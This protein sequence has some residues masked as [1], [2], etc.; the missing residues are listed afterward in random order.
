MPSLTVITDSQTD[1]PRELAEELGILIAPVRVSI[2]RKDCRDKIDISNEEIYIEGWDVAAGRVNVVLCD[3]FLGNILVK[4]SAGLG[5]V[6]AHWSAQQ[7]RG[8][9][10]KPKLEKLMDRFRAL[11]E[12]DERAGGGPLLGIE[13]V[14]VIGHGRSRASS[15]GGAIDQARRAAEGGLVEGLRAELTRVAATISSDVSLSK[16]AIHAFGLS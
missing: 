4:Y 13:G 9:L 12:M 7:L 15:V 11:V 6:L 14:M 10:P 16:S 5:N 3:G 2:N 8:Q 1:I